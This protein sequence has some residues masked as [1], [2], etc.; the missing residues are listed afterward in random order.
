VYQGRWVAQAVLSLPLQWG[1]LAVVARRRRLD[2]PHAEPR[3][4]GHW[5][6][7]L[8]GGLVTALAVIGFVLRIRDVA[9]EPLN[10]DEVTVYRATRG[11]LER[12][13][14]KFVIHE[15]IP[16]KDICTSEII[17][18][19]TALAALLFEGDCQ[20]VRVPAVCWGT[21]TILLIFVVGR[22]L[23]GTTVGLIAAALYTFS[24]YCIQMS[25]FGRYFSQL[26]FI[27]LLTVYLF[28]RLIDGTGPI[29]RRMLWLTATS[30]AATFLSWEGSALLA[31]GMVLAALLHRRGHLRTIL[32]RP[33]VYAAMVAVL[34]VVVLQYTHRVLQQTQQLQY[35]TGAGDLSLRPMWRYPGFDLW[36]YAWQAS[37]NQD[38]LIP[39]IGFLAAGL[40]AIQHAWHHR[41]RFL[42]LILLANCWIMAL[43]LPVK[44]PRYSYHLTPL[45]VLLLA[46]AIGAV[47]RAIDHFAR[48]GAAR[49]AAQAYALAC[50]WFGALVTTVFGCGIAIQLPEMGMFCVS[51]YRLQV[52][53]FP[54][55]RGSIMFLRNHVRD[56]DVVLATTPHVIDH[57]MAARFADFWL[58]SRLQLQAVL[59]D[60]RTVPLHRLSGTEMVSSIENLRDIFARG[61]RVW[62]LTDTTMH[63]K[64]NDPD[65]SSYLRQHMEV[66]YEDFASSVL[67][68]GEH[69]RSALQRSEDE[70]ALHSAGAN[71]LH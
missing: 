28:W 50:G 69:H 62:Y 26:Q 54:D 56:G 60:Y 51:A 15:D 68:W 65:V 42:M 67:F 48:S 32:Q 34:V 24:P 2:R 8:V 9:T 61:G 49:P 1:V 25:N 39:A 46:A 12:G 44:A 22:R 14:P 5:R 23:F 66:V 57:L 3:E 29:D 59:D 37:W 16:V 35:G 53:K 30:F 38:A 43:F 55:E 41:I 11:F 70:R 20:V 31:P 17:Y 13:F 40:L 21:G 10:P 71:V 18:I 63:D 33:A 58:Q 4:A 64:L 6:G 27:T 36:Y 45:L 47:M 19:G 7:A 52:L